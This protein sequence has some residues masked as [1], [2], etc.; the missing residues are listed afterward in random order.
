MNMIPVHEQDKFTCPHCL[1]VAKQDWFFGYK[2]KEAVYDMY[3]HEFLT[4]RS[5]ISDYK[6]DAIKSFL[7]YM[8][9]KLQI[10]IDNRLLPKNFSIARCHACNDYSVWIDE[11]IIYPKSISIEV[12]N[13][14]VNEDIKTL[15]NEARVIF[16]DSPKG[17]TALLRLAL[18][19]LLTQMGKDGKNINKNIKELVNEGLNP[20]VQKALD[21]LRVVGNNAVHP[22]QIDLDDNRDIA[23][24]LFKIFNIIAD[25]MISKPKEMNDLYDEIIPEETKKHINDR[26]GN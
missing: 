2:V 25:D 12:P 13:Q 10:H 22:G 3:K 4:Y 6:A 19:K 15:Y 26:D 7:E 8:Q 23:L 16:L 20:K 5:G 14:D 24:K 18:Q 21:I 9:S 1:V 11:N 17:A